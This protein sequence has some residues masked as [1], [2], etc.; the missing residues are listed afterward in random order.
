MNI[1]KL[2]RKSFPHMDIYRGKCVWNIF[3]NNKVID[4]E[5]NI[6]DN[7]WIR[8]AKIIS[9]AVGEDSNYKDFYNCECG[10]EGAQ[11]TLR[12][13]IDNGWKINSR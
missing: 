7:T 9:L 13:L 3:K 12:I 5:G 4:P 2:I 6:H 11:E 8:W 1:E 10:E